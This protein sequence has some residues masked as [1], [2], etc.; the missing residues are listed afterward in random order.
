MWFGGGPGG[1]GRGGSGPVKKWELS[2]WGRSGW[3]PN[4]R[5]FF[6]SRPF[7]FNFRGVSWNCGGLC[8]FSSL[9]MSSQHTF[10]IL[11]TSCDAPADT[12]GMGEK[13]TKRGSGEEK[14][15]RGILEGP[16]TGSRVG[17]SRA[18]V[19]RAG[20]PGA[21]ERGPGHQD[22]WTKLPHNQPTDRPTDRPTDQPTI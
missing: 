6:L 1:D 5:A 19:S 18:G 17:V 9:K 3:G 2:G 11:W 22:Q 4:F 8:A 13:K 14:Q 10:G 7:F 21:G 15:K 16:G 20:A 12:S